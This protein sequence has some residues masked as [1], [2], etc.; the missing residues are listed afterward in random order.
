MRC[1]IGAHLPPSLAGAL[2]ECRQEA[3]HVFDLLPVDA[4]DTV[5]WRVA[6]DSGY[7]LVTKDEDFAEWSRLRE[8]APSVLW[9]RIGNLKKV[10]LRAK[11]VPLLPELVEQ[12]QAGETLIEVFWR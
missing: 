11:L 8:P 2:R 5:I 10:E 1:L 9:L 6:L 4:R 7:V 12:L 3:V